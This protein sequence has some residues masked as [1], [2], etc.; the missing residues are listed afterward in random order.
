M[1][2]RTA[3]AL[4]M[5]LLAAA[6]I[7]TSASAHEKTRAEVRQELIQA[8]NDGTRF[9]TETSYPDVARIYQMQAAQRTQQS[10]DAY[11]ADMGGSSAS[12]KAT[13]SQTHATPASC[14]GPVSFCRPFFGR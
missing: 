13:G 6:G 10:A 5:A 2:K 7:E 8:E 14:L 11:G 4:S 12:G 3:I 9:V 1:K